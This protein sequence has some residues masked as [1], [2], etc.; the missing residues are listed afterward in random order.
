MPDILNSCLKHRFQRS[1][2]VCSVS[3]CCVCVLCVLC[4]LLCSVLVL[5]CC[6]FVLVLVC[7]L[8]S[9]LA[10]C[11]YFA[12]SGVLGGLSSVVRF[13]RS[14]CLSLLVALSFAFVGVLIFQDQFC[15]ALT[16]DQS[17][18]KLILK[19][20][21]T[22]RRKGKRTQEEQQQKGKR[23]RRDV[24]KTSISEEHNT[25]KTKRRRREQRFEAHVLRPGI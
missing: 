3:C 21:H 25:R 22:T 19:N 23:N 15:H 1:L 4:L 9:V 24:R 18:T 7:L 8:C 16:L 12:P 20:Q 11:C 5:M 14:C 17:V 2:A 13:S 10:C 6:G